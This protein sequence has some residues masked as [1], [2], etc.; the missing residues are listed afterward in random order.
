MQKIDTAVVENE[1]VAGE[2]LAEVR[3]SDFGLSRSQSRKRTAETVGKADFIAQGAW[4]SER[5]VL[6]S[7]M[8]A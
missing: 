5:A 6:P 1:I 8:V 4:R 7:L 2:K 3:A